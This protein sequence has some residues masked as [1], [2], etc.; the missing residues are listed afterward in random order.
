MANAQ[1]RSSE[2][3]AKSAVRAKDPD[4]QREEIDLADTINFV[5]V[6]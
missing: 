6:S 2:K 1:I 3:A 4:I 5:L